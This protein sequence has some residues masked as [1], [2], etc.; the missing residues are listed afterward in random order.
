[1]WQYTAAAQ[2]KFP[3][4]D[5]KVYCIVQLSFSAETERINY[6]DVWLSKTINTTW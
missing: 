5:N 4:G 2:E 1:M 6:S 3:H